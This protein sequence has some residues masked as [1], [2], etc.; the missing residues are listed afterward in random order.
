MLST[1]RTMQIIAQYCANAVDHSDSDKANIYHNQIYVLCKISK[2]FKDIVLK[3]KM[4]QSIIILSHSV[5]KP[6]SICSF[7]TVLNFF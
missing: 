6:Q 1:L 5:L 2:L 3:S 7:S 4:L